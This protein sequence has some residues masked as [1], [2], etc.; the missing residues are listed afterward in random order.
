LGLILL[1]VLVET[2]LEVSVFFGVENV[3][4][5]K[6]SMCVCNMLGHTRW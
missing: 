4:K 2:L 6:I 1:N 5:F 3:H